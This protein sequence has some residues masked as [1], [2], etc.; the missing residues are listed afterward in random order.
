MQLQR[1][2]AYIC[3]DVPQGDVLADAG[4]DVGYGHFGC[5]VISSGH[6]FY[7]EMV[8]V[9]AHGLIL[10][11]MQEAAMVKSYR[12]PE[13]VIVEAA[14]KAEDRTLLTIDEETQ[15]QPV[16]A[17]PSDAQDADADISVEELGEMMKSLTLGGKKDGNN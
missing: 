1:S 17:E 5:P 8:F 14:A 4:P 13:V 6:S 9:E 15:E 7:N 2:R 12:N 10:D 16:T 11:W 3:S